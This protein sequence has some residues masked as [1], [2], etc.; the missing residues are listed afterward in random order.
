FA[1]NRKDSS[2]FRQIIYKI[3]DFSQATD[4]PQ[5]WLL[6][7][8][9]QGANTYKDFSAIPEQEVKDFLNT[10]QETALALRDVTDLEDYKQVTAKGTPTAAY[11]R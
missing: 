2:N 4:N 6:E 3:Y 8:F 1:G 10:L 11:Q 9:L 7:N 5:R